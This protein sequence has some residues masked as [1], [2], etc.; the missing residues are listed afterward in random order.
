[1]I[2]T[3]L[4]AASI[5]LTGC[6]NHTEGTTEAEVK[7]VTETP[8]TTPAPAPAPAPAGDML[9][10]NAEDSKIEWVGAKITKSHPGGFNDFTVEATVDGGAL[11]A[12][13]STVQIASMFSDSAKLTGHLLDA[14][15]FD[16]A[17]FATAS[18]TSTSIVADGDKHK[19]TGV[20]EMH[21]VKKEL[22]FPATITVTDGKATFDAEFNINRSD[23][24]ITYP[25]RPDDAIKEQVVIKLDLNLS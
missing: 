17:S 18:F 19:V 13:N 3:L 14:D 1:M 5:G 25:G 24:G 22:S 11:T 8:A 23:W 21:G 15:F 7:D 12:I 20:M 9:R 2:R 6:V 16:A 10:A 4:L